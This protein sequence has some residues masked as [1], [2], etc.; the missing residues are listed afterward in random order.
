MNR[1]TWLLTVAAL[2]PVV[3]AAEDFADSPVFVLDAP[4]AAL[5]PYVEDVP[6][7][8]V[9]ALEDGV[10][11]AMRDLDGDGY[12]DAFQDRNGDGT[13]DAFEQRNAQGQYTGLL[14]VNDNTFPDWF[15][16]R[17]ATPVAKFMITNLNLDTATVTV[18]NVSVSGAPGAARSRAI[19][20]T[21]ATAR[22]STASSHLPISTPHWIITPSR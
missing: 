19:T 17:Y 20:G 13:P 22:P 14:D 4:E 18:R 11:E 21:S 10:P 6:Y 7:T 12:P 5:A 8:A 1:W 9:S 3:C 15:E 16:T 2:L